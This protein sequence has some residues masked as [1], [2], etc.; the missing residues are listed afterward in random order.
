MSTSTRFNCQ[1][2]VAR[3]MTGSRA[4]SNRSPHKLDRTAHSCGSADIWLLSV[5]IMYGRCDSPVISPGHSPPGHP[6]SPPYTNPNPH[7]KLVSRARFFI[8]VKTFFYVFLFLSRL[9]VLRLKKMFFQ[10]FSKKRYTNRTYII[11]FE[12]EHL[13]TVAINTPVYVLFAL[14]DIISVSNKLTLLMTTDRI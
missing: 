3:L 11:K 2:L 4:V 5:R 7:P 14:T 13:K 9:C 10:T 12:R 1:L 8:D 6:P